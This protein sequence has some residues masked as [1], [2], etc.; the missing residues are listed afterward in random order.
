VY[1]FLFLR[2][3][4]I[5]STYFLIENGELNPVAGYLIKQGW[6]YYIL[7]QVI[8]SIIIIKLANRY[9]LWLPINLLS[10]VV[11]LSNIMGYLLFLVYAYR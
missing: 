6:G 7:F 11:V 4:D 9:R 1:L 8:A 5:S 2:L 10:F 3:L